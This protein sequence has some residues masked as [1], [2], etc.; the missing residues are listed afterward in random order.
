MTLPDVLTGQELELRLRAVPFDG[1]QLETE[2][3]DL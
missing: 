3:A 1:G 2:A